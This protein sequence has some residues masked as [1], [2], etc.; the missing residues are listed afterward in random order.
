MINP[1]SMSPHRSA[2][3]AKFQDRPG[4]VLAIMCVGMFLVLLDV[5]VVN[6]ALPHDRR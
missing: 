3:D 5:T 6:V 4:R 2:G 1:S